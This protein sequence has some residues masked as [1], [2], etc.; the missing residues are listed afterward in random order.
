MATADDPKKEELRTKHFTDSL[1]LTQKMRGGLFTMPVSNAIGDTNYFPN[2]K[3]R[4]DSEGAVITDPRNF[5]TKKPKKGRGP[6]VTFSKPVFATIGDPYKDGGNKPM[7]T[8]KHEGYKDAGHDK[9]FKPAMNISRKVKADFDHLTDLVEKKK[10]HK[11]E[12][13]HVILEPRNFLTNP[14]KQGE[15]GKGTSFGGNL[16]HMPEQYDYK[17]EVLTKERKIHESTLQEKPW[18]QMVKQKD[19]FNPVK[20]VF[21]TDVPPVKEEPV[22]KVETTPH[23]PLHDKPFKPSNPAKKGYNKTLDKFPEFKPDPM[24]FITRK[25]PV[26]GEEVKPNFRPSHNVKTMSSIPVATNYRN[27]KT[28]FPSIFRR[29]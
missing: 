21:G 8:A 26:E 11:G 3:A 20:E 23:E 28:E 14:P 1:A 17:Q 27:L 29:L 15:V 12:D 18:S 2:K 16:P 10:S 19:T 22:V 24:T 5:T 7:R 25:K 13:G 9:D 4:R 6:E